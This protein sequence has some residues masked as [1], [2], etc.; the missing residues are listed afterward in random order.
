MK[1]NNKNNNIFSGDTWQCLLCSD[2]RTVEKPPEGNNGLSPT[3]LRLAQRI[4]LE[5]FCHY[6]PSLH[7]REVVG[8]QVLPYFF[9]LK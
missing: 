9:I 5:L 3:E 1:R 8:L 2:V 6:E 7:F 4:L